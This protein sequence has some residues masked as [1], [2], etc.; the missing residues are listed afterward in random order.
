MSRTS[1]K[2]KDA[3]EGQKADSVSSVGSEEDEEEVEDSDREET[4]DL[5]R[6][7]ALGMFGGVS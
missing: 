6:N 5:Y 7:S 2:N 1:S 3:V 4:P